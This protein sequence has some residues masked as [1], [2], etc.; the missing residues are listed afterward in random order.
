MAIRSGR[1]KGDASGNGIKIIMARSVDA[2]HRIFNSGTRPFEVHAGHADPAK[3]DPTCSLDV[4]VKN[5]KEV[6]IK[7]DT[8]KEVEGIYDFLDTRGSTRS[9]RFTGDASG[10]GITILQGIQGSEKRFYRIFNSGQD[11]FE[12]HG[13]GKGATTLGPTFSLDVIVNGD[14]VIKTASAGTVEGIYD[15]LDT[16]GSV[17]SGRFNLKKAPTT[18]HKIIDLDTSGPKA[19]VFYRIFNS[20]DNPFTV[21]AAAQELVELGPAQSFDFGVGQKRDIYVAADAYPIEGIYEFL[22]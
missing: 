7:S 5:K 4:L 9:G 17:R 12:V 21:L 16:A 15:R 11:P 2:A 19:E 8:A 10:T 14:V 18:N 6:V 3:L 22:G 13:G 1:F 20:G